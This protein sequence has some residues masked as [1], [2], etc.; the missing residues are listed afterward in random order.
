MELGWYFH[1]QVSAVLHQKSIQDDVASLVSAR[2]HRSIEM[3]SPV[4]LCVCRH[5]SAH[6]I[7]LFQRHH[8]HDQVH[9]SYTNAAFFAQNSL[10]RA[11]DFR[12]LYITEKMWRL[13]PEFVSE[14]A[15]SEQELD[16]LRVWVLA[17]CEPP[18]AKQRQPLFVFSSEPP[19]LPYRYFKTWVRGKEMHPT[20]AKLL[21]FSASELE[22]AGFNC[23]F[24]NLYRNGLDSVPAHRD[25]T[26]AE[27]PILSL[28]FYQ[29]DHGDD[30]IRSLTVLP[31]DPAEPITELRMPHRS[32]VVMLPGMQQRYRHAVPSVPDSRVWRLNVTFRKQDS[33]VCVKCDFRPPTTRCAN[34]E[35][36][37]CG[38]CANVI[39]QV[40]EAVSCSRCTNPCSYCDRYTCCMSRGRC[41][42]CRLEDS[43]RHWKALFGLL[44]QE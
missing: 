19:G 38:D 14:Q 33:R 13:I 39:C 8:P 34:C 36:L 18:R 22:A 43:L 40:C 41:K 26:H 9:I 20:L 27:D 23:V 11:P 35:S 12:P 5:A 32:A 29:P 31:D 2:S 42:V 37:V 28:S 10:N 6:A 16:D 21:T 30:D 7:F 1:Q 44:F 25:S 24:V 17:C 3:N 15:V 4:T